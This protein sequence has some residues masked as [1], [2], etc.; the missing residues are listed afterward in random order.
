MNFYLAIL[1]V[2][3][4]SFWPKQDIY[5]M[6]LASLSRKSRKNKNRPKKYAL[7]NRHNI[8]SLKSVLKIQHCA[9][10]LKVRTKVSRHFLTLFALQSDVVVAVDVVPL[11]LLLLLLVELIWSESR[12]NNFWSSWSLFCF[13]SWNTKKIK[14][15]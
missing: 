10:H 3:L 11:L 6:I 9:Q 14:M 13:S 15:Q 8:D 7:N 5:I 2:Y 4:H 1:N 12:L